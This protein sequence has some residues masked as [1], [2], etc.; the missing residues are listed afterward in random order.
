MLKNL[1]CSNIA[2]FL[3][4]CI[5]ASQFSACAWRLASSVDKKDSRTIAIPYVEGDSSGRLTNNLVEQIEKQT[6][7]VFSGDGGELT[8]KVVLVDNTYDNIGFRFDPKKLHEH[9]H[10]KKLIP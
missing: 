2:L 10:E 3:F 5:S 6:G 7:L 1:R 4:A 9:G 8:L